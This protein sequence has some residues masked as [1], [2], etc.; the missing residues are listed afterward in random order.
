[1]S[2]IEWHTAS[3]KSV[4][5]ISADTDTVIIVGPNAEA[6]R[7]LFGAAGDMLDALTKALW[8]LSGI[9]AETL[10]EHVAGYDLAKS[11]AALRE[12]QREAVAACKAIQDAI[13]KVEGR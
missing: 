3:Y 10:P 7:L 1:M 13:A 4:T 8:A 6:N 12:C 2:N 11:K 5:N 9:G